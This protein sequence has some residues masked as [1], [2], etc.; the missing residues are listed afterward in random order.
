MISPI[1]ICWASKV[2]QLLLDGRGKSDEEGLKTL[3][4]VPHRMRVN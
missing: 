4:P 1:Q 2:L 3:D